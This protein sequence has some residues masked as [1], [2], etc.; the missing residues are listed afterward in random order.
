MDLYISGHVY[1]YLCNGG[2]ISMVVVKEKIIN[3][4]TAQLV[5]A[6]DNS[7]VQVFYKGLCV[8]ES[9]N[10]TWLNIKDSGLLENY[11]TVVIEA[12]LDRIKR[13]KEF[14][15]AWKELSW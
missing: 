1:S 12:Y 14:D 4:A 5:L 10:N 3:G 15:E 13:D 11:L 9:S 7:T 2:L 6:D 8:D